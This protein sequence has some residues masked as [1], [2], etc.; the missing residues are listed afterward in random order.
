MNSLSISF[1]SFSPSGKKTE[2][3]SDEKIEGNEE[4]TKGSGTW[5][6]KI[7]TFERNYIKSHEKG[8]E[9]KKKTLRREK[10]RIEK[11]TGSKREGI[12]LEGREKQDT[13]DMTWDGTE[14]FTAQTVQVQTSFTLVL[15]EK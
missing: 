5:V 11:N 7:D 10:K 9:N 6:R 12:S 4:G 14:I 1:F 15:R 13:L 3:R 2:T 8:Y